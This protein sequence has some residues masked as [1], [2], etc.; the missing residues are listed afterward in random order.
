MLKLKEKEVRAKIEK[1]GLSVTQFAHEYGFKQ[2]TLA[3]WIIGQRNPRRNSVFELAKALNCQPEE[4]AEI[5][6]VIN[7]EE[8]TITDEKNQL[9]FF[10]NMLNDGQRQTILAVM[11]TMIKGGK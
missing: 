6:C 5:V 3:S 4:I 7:T 9:L 1:T 11:E 10:W 2:S 8:E